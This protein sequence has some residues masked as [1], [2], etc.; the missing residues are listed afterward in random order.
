[1]TSRDQRLSTGADAKGRS[2]RTD[3]GW[4]GSARSGMLGVAGREGDEEAAV[5][6]AVSRYSRISGEAPSLISADEG[7]QE[8]ASSA[9]GLARVG[10]SSSTGGRS[11]V[12]VY[13]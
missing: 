7:Y 8:N 12:R 11:D 5:G 3:E 2:R 10:S 9:G 6:T 4:R 1:M 13:I